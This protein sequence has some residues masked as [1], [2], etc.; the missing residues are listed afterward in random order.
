[1]STSK[2]SFGKSLF[3]VCASAA[4]A[5]ALAGMIAA[6]GG[7]LNSEP[8]SAAKLSFGS[9]RRIGQI[10]KNPSTPFLRYAPDGR[11]YA[12]WTEDDVG[13]VQVA[14]AAHQHHRSGKVSGKMAPSSMR[15]VLL[16]ASDDS[17]AN[18]SAPR[19][20]NGAREAAQGEENGPRIA[21]GAKGEL[22]AVW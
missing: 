15:A 8:Q 19:R 20:V 10:E 11:L 13:P 12:I 17:G 21:F 9:E 18:W 14:D 3:P 4:T 22:Y 2:V 6:C 1:M 5:L 7:L 16:A